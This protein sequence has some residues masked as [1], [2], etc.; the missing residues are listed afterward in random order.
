MHI[1]GVEI[2]IIC[3]LHAVADIAPKVSDGWHDIVHVVIDDVTVFV[4]IAIVHLHWPRR[5]GLVSNQQVKIRVY[6]ILR[7][8]YR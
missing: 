2:A 4:Q 8:Y 6:L 3:Y 7:K 5:I 1:I